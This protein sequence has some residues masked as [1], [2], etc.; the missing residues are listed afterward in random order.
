MPQEKIIR[1]VE[2]LDAEKTFKNKSKQLRQKVKT[3]SKNG[4]LDIILTGGFVPQGFKGDITMEI[5]SWENDWYGKN[6][7]KTAPI[8]HENRLGRPNSGQR[9]YQGEE[10]RRINSMAIAYTKDLVVSDKFDL[11]SNEKDFYDTAATMANWIYSY[12]ATF[13][14]KENFE[15]F[16]QQN[17]VE[18][19]DTP[20]F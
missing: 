4:E 8:T 9:D 13:I 14:V 10:M 3:M 11:I 5:W 20:P 17:P 18:E 6:L 2:I 7:S 1:K 15:K 16:A 12:K 19:D